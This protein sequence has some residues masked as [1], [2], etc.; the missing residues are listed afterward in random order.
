ML[1]YCDIRTDTTPNIHKSTTF[2]SVTVSRFQL[3]YLKN[4]FY[5]IIK[6]SITYL[7]SKCLRFNNLYVG[8][9]KH[10][11]VIGGA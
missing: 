7:S 10:S 11:D 6:K 5:F 9:S 1:T 3:P 2:Y 4:L 8:I